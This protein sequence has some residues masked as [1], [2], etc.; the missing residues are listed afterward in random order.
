MNNNDTTRQ[1]LLATLM[2]LGELFPDWRIGQTLANLSMA[3]GHTD[4]GAVW[5]LEDHEALSAAR[6]LL[7]R[8]VERRHTVSSKAL[9]PVL[10][11]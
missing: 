8:H 5:D 2:E 7:E 3:T 1:E 11:H 4:A 10:S 9:A 6:H